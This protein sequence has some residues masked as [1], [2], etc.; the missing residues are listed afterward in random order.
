MYIRIRLPHFKATPDTGP[1][2]NVVL[3]HSTGK[4][5]SI[6]VTYE[7][8]LKFKKKIPFHVCIIITLQ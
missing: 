6:P 2:I 5:L 7:W 8:D 4:F 1:W 3:K